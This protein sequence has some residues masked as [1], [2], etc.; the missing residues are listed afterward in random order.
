MHGFGRSMRERGFVYRGPAPVPSVVAQK[1][2]LSVSLFLDSGR[3]E[4]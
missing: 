1:V 2:R 3:G 4:E